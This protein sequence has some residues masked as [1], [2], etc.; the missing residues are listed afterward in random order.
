[1]TESKQDCLACKL[2]G[3][4]VGFGISGYCLYERTQVPTDFSLAKVIKQN[5]MEWTKR[6]SRVHRAALLGMSAGKIHIFIIENDQHSMK[7]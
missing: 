3:T 7:S 6:S 2:T 4:V 5:D 1:M